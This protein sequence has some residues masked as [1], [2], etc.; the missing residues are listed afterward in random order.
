[1]VLVSICDICKIRRSTSSMSLSEQVV[2]AWETSFPGPE[3]S[4]F[5]GSCCGVLQFG[6]PIL[7]KFRE[8]FGTSNYTDI[9]SCP[10][11]VQ[12]PQILVFRSMIDRAVFVEDSNTQFGDVREILRSL[13][14]RH[15]QEKVDDRMPKLFC[16]VQFN[17][18]SLYDE[19]STSEGTVSKSR[20]SNS[21]IDLPTEIV[22][23][24]NQRM[25]SSSRHFKKFKDKYSVSIGDIQSFAESVRGD[26]T[27]LFQALFPNKSDITAE[28]DMKRMLTES[29]LSSPSGFYPEITV[30]LR[31]DTIHLVGKYNK[32]CRNFGQSQWDA[33]STSVAESICPV[34]CDL[35]KAPIDKCL[36][37]ASGR[38]DM[39]VRML[40][41]G[42]TFVLQLGDAHSLHPLLDQTILSHFSVDTG[43]V[44]VEGGLR[45]VDK[46]VLDW[47]HWSTEQHLKVYRCVVWSAEE[48]S[49]NI[50]TILSSVKSLKVYQKT[51]MRV[52]HR[53]SDNTR[54]KY[55]HSISMDVLNS[56]FG[57]VTL[58]ASAGAYIK[59][60][61]HGD[62][63]RTK[64]SFSDV[65]FGKQTK[66][67]I[68]QLDV[69]EVEQDEDEAYVP[70]WDR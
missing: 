33:N 54:E 27:K 11:S 29:F 10:L 42:R 15:I 64:P 35:F 47:L 30:S 62:L 53:R 1:M 18:P 3:S 2:S 44:R 57:I 37:S 66:C 9:Y 23:A 4:E 51:P 56:H 59:E 45:H 67:D 52:L 69:L 41:N 58:H 14:Y 25:K 16:D 40:G 63:G 19:V 12:L 31:R 34:V 26:I 43:D 60:F 68:L 21:S 39:D 38:E 70:L 32:H 28:S 6:G 65:V 61:I 46:G 17:M 49:P 55:I 20:R 48:F 22:S 36:F 24:V 8:S 7:T 13:L 50:E 5:C